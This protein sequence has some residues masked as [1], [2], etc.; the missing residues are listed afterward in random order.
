MEEQEVNTDELKFYAKDV[1][2]NY[3]NGF[4]LVNTFKVPADTVEAAVTKTWV[5][6]NNANGKRPASIKYVLSGNNQT[7]EQIVT[8]NTNSDADWN[9]T[10]TNLPK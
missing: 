6:S 8:G 5:D 10:F 1:N 7:K 3:K 2:G 9:Y 4:N